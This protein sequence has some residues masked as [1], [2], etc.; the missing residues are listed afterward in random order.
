MTDI[1]TRMTPSEHAVLVCA[2]NASKIPGFQLSPKVAH[3][4]SRMARDDIL[5][6][7][8]FITT[9]FKGDRI[10]SAQARDFAK[11][12]GRQMDS[13]ARLR[14]KLAAKRK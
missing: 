9:L 2:G 13:R 7:E 14:A 6:P 3:T 1:S 8:Q 12:K 4:L 10:V 11:V 5:T